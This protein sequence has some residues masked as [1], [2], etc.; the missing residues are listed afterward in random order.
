MLSMHWAHLV[1]AARLTR[2][3]GVKAADWL[4]PPVCLGCGARTMDHAG[5]CQVCWLDLKPITTPR[6]DVTGQPFPYDPGEGVVSAAALADPPAWDR[7]RAAVEF[8]ETSRR[9]VHALKYHDRHEAGRL[10]A[11]MM[12]VA[13]HDLI[14]TDAVLAPVP[15]YRWRLW[16]RRFNQ[17]AIL[18]R[19]VA[20]AGG[21]RLVVDLVIRTRSTATQVGLDVHG[22]RANVSRAFAVNADRSSDVSGRHVVVVDD[23]ITTGATAGAVARALKKAGAARVDVLAFALVVKPAALHI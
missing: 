22:R 20:A 9:L 18:A 14:S 19:H 11:R 21:N 15:L 13:G 8:N 10:M 2:L 3:I 1:N 4:L 23:V 17:S 7:A 5:L 12:T 6:C 16:G